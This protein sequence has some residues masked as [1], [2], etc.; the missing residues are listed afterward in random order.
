MMVIGALALAGCVGPLVP[1]TQVEEPVA[2]ELTQTIAVYEPKDTSSAATILGPLTATSCKNK[3]WDKDATAEDAINQLRLLARQH[4]GDAVGNLVCE[5]PRGT[6]L[7][8]NCWASVTCT[9]S[10]IK[11]VGA[12]PQ[13]PLRRR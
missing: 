4:G 10:A 1:V 13:R 6:E 2:A 11:L 5:P 12:S 7:A 8:K 3:M 9:G